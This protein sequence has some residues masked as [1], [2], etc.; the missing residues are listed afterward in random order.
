MLGAFRLLN[1]VAVK[2][3]AV[4]KRRN[5]RNVEN[6][7]R[8]RS[9]E[10]LF[11]GSPEFVPKEYRLLDNVFTHYL[12]HCCA[13]RAKTDKRRQAYQKG[14]RVF[15]FHI[16]LNSR[17]NENKSA[18]QHE[19]HVCINQLPEFIG[20]NFPE[21]E[22]RLLNKGVPK[23]E[24]NNGTAIMD[25]LVEK[26]AKG[27]VSAIKEVLAILEKD[28]NDKRSNISKLYKALSDED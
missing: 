1:K 4:S 16:K 2:V 15:G 14:I 26:A 7:H 25:A 6:S 10:I 3:K 9:F 20:K 23:A 18:E 19:Q 13:G 22:K 28:E 21:F 17:H 27:E 5:K 8:E 11:E 24:I 12:R